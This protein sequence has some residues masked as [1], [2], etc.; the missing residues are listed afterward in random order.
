MTIFKKRHVLHY[1]QNEID[2]TIGKTQRSKSNGRCKGQI[3]CGLRHGQKYHH[4][5]NNY[6]VH[7]QKYI[8]LFRCA[9]RSQMTHW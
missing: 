7:L 6:Y 5:T 8:P 9:N 1:R 2:Q 3:V 4:S